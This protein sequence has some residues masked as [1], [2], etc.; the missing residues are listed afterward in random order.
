MSLF[1]NRDDASA[2]PMSGGEQKRL[3]RLQVWVWGKQFGERLKANALRLR[4][5]LHPGG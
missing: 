1:S 3:F 2:A 5:F 4:R